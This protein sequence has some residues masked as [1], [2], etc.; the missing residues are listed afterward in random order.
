M[1]CHAA[2]D[3]GLPIQNTGLR[4]SDHRNLTP[5]L[6]IILLDIL[7]LSLNSEAVE[8]WSAWSFKAQRVWRRPEGTT[9]QHHLGPIPC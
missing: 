8:A 1:H 9:E 2:Q 3:A 7:H 5:Q 6:D 4:Y